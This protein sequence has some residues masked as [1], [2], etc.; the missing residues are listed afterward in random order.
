MRAVMGWEQLLIFLAV[1]L[2]VYYTLILL[3]FYRKEL[4]GLVKRKPARRVHATAAES[5][6]RGEQPDRILYNRV[7]ELM[8][9]CKPVFKAAVEQSLEKEQV[10]AA[11]RV[12]LQQYPE[13]R[14]TAF[15]ISITSH[16]AQEMDHR[17]NMVLTD[18]ETE[19]LWL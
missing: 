4:F 3:L 11:L 12:R 7:L 2:G 13:I 1:F 9:D 15:Q 16:I 17:L 5:E 14:G 19:L 6:Q 8:Q 10:L 18:E